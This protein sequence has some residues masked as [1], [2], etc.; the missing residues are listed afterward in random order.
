MDI[1]IAPTGWFSIITSCPSRLISGMPGHSMECIGMAIFFPGV[2]RYT[3]LSPFSSFMVVW[4]L[5]FWGWGLGLGLMGFE[6]CGVGPAGFFWVGA[7][8]IN[9]EE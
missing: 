2:I 5:G 9:I 7:L 1:N 3:L 6:A 4:G 8:Y